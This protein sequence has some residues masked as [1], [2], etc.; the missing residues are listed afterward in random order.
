M[1]QPHEVFKKYE[2][3][4]L[5]PLPDQ[6]PPMGFGMGVPRVGRND[7]CPC[8]SGLKYRTVTE[9]IIADEN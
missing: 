9:N 2:K 7:L 4:N 8:G 5:Q 1:G 6:K 3:P